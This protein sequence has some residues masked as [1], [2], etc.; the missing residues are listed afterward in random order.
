M[1][2]VAARA[3]VPLHVVGCEEVAAG[4]RWG[5]R[6][7]SSGEEEEEEEEGDGS[8]CGP[9]GSTLIVHPPMHVASSQCGN[10]HFGRVLA[11]HGPLFPPRPQ[12]SSGTGA[13]MAP[14]NPPLSPRTP[15]FSTPSLLPGDSDSPMACAPTPTVGAPHPARTPRAAHWFS[16]RS[17]VK[18]E[19]KAHTTKLT[20]ARCSPC[21]RAGAV[22]SPTPAPERKLKIKL[23]KKKNNPNMRPLKVHFY[24]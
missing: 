7:H 1:A 10:P 5:V 12:L 21:K 18:A 19:P 3:D 8:S 9:A 22:S 13:G 15:D 20:C 2:A 4:I 24:F 11:P 17:R 16:W 14:H 23:I 6:G